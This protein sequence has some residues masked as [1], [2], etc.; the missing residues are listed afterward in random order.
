MLTNAYTPL[1]IL[2][3][4]AVLVWL[5]IVGLVALGLRAAISGRDIVWK[6]EVPR[7]MALAIATVAGLLAD[8]AA[9]AGI[10]DPPRRQPVLT[11]E[12]IRGLCNRACR[13]FVRARVPAS[14][15]RRGPSYPRQG[16]YWRNPRLDHRHHHVI[17]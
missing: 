4:L 13:R 11:W 8:A 3:S 16:F 14:R 6:W 1:V 17:Y 10:I 7:P 5:L 15:T 9:S 2:T 12:E